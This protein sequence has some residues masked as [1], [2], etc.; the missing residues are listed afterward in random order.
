MARIAKT[1]AYFSLETGFNP[2]GA[3]GPNGIPVLTNCQEHFPGHIQ[4]ASFDGFFGMP[5]KPPHLLLRIG[6]YNNFWRTKC[7]GC[8][9]ILHADSA[10]WPFRYYPA[11]QSNACSKALTCSSSSELGRR[12]NDLRTASSSSSKGD[13]RRHSHDACFINLIPC[14]YI[15]ITIFVYN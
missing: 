14:V 12:S 5:C 8:V 4:A 15:R 11:S 9:Q 13:L 10:H 1:S 3:Q 2:Q 6:A 7:H